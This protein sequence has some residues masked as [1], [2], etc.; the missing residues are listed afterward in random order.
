[1]AL[2]IEL[3]NISFSLVFFQRIESAVLV[4]WGFTGRSAVH[5]CKI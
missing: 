1:M 5:M 3:K 4:F 2:V